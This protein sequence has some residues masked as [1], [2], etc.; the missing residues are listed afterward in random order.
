MT[1]TSGNFGLAVSKNDD[2]NA[3]L[4]GRMAD[5]VEPDGATSGTI[6]TTRRVSLASGDTLRPKFSGSVDD[7]NLMSFSVAPA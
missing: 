2:T 6:T 4:L 1:G 7:I 5:T 3:S